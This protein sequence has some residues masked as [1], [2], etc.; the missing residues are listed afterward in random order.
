MA[1]NELLAALETLIVELKKD[2]KQGPAG[3][4]DKIANEIKKTENLNTGAK[5]LSDFRGEGHNEDFSN[6]QEDLLDEVLDQAALYV[7]NRP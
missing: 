7:G 6:E 4:L 1:Q 3:L 2:G 5:S